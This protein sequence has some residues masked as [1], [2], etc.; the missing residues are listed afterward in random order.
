M[1]VRLWLF[2]TLTLLHL[3]RI[4]SWKLEATTNEASGVL[5]DWHSG[6]HYRDVRDVYCTDPAV[7]YIYL[8]L[9][10]DYLS[11]FA[12][13]PHSSKKTKL[14]KVSYLLLGLTSICLYWHVDIISV[15]ISFEADSLLG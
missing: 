15:F 7:E 11:P 6:K 9:S 10:G 12:R 2:R 5:V 3:D 1:P 8:Q 4:T 13:D 14:K